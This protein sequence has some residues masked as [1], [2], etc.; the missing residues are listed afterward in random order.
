MTCSVQ[1]QSQSQKSTP[2]DNLQVVE[3]QTVL[4]LYIYITLL[5]DILIV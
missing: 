1:D 4:I 5:I 2:Q 3:H